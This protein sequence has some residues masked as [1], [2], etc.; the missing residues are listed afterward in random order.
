MSDLEKETTE[1]KYGLSLDKIQLNVAL[2]LKGSIPDLERIVSK[3]EKENG[4]F[5]VYKK[6][7]SNRFSILEEQIRT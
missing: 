6:V 2:I 4:I 7:S 5:V 3:L 1:N